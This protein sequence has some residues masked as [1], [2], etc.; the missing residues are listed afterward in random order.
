MPH[1][2]ELESSIMEIVWAAAGPVTVRQVVDALQQDRQIAYTTV[3][4]VMDILYR[5]GWLTRHKDGRANLYQATATRA[6]Y[7]ARLMDEA[8][9]ATPDRSAALATFVER[10]SPDEV[11]ELR[12]ALEAAR[13]RER[14]P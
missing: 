11:D 1:F 9:A 3:Q 2:G 14:E 4:T 13:L 8:L 6:D 12:S 5:K 10:M 7:V